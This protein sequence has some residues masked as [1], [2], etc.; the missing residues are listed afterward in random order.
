MLFM[1]LTQQ[2]GKFCA[3]VKFL[4]A[5]TQGWAVVGGKQGQAPALEEWQA[6]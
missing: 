1:W 4:P 2:A 3:E 6:W 5:G